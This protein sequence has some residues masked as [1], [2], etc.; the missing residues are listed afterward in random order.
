MKRVLLGLSNN[1]HLNKNKI[2][3]WVNSFRQF[4]DDDI[5]L[6]AAN[7]NDDDIAT[8]EELNIKYKAVTIE[9]TWYIN[10]KRLEHTLNYLIESDIDLFLITDVFDVAFQGNPFLKMDIDNYDVF[11]SGEGILVGQEPWNFDNINKIFP[12]EISK[13]INN[14]IICS[15]II[16]GKREPLIKLYQRM[17]ELCELGSNDHNIKDQAALIVMIA[18]NEIDKLKV[19]N[20]DDGWAMHCAVAGPT[21]FFISWGF[22]NNIKYGIPK[23]ENNNITTSEGANYDIVHQFNR[24]PE[25]NNLLNEKYNIQ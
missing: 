12:D 4:C 14:E 5:I 20:L 15:G 21:Q 25:W 11:V 6:L 2:K 10:H 23:L 17:F 8:C 16:G 19:F 13:C 1:I 3:L 18:N 9:D 22:K 7:I 24:V